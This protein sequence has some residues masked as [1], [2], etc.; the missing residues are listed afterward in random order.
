MDLV[1]LYTFSARSSGLL[2]PGAA[3][4][5]NPAWTLRN[6]ESWVDRGKKVLEKKKQQQQQQQQQQQHQE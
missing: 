5:L 6:S 4:R 2:C 3:R 1:V